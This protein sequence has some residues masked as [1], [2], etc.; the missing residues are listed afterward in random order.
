MARVRLVIDWAPY[1]PGS[2]AELSQKRAVGHLL[3]EAP[4]W[5]EIVVGSMGGTIGG[6]HAWPRD[7]HGEASTKHVPYIRD[8]LDYACFGKGT[9]AS[10]VELAGFLNSDII[11]TPKFFT[12]LKYALDTHAGT[13][14][15]SRTDCSIT[16]FRQFWGHRCIARLHGKRVLARVSTD[17][18][19]MKPVTWRR[20]REVMPDFV[21][22]EPYWDTAYIYWA[23]H[24]G[25]EHYVHM[26][27]DECVHLRHGGNWDFTTD[28]AK[29]ARMLYNSFVPPAERVTK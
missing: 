22:G 4:D 11:V 12:A 27:E 6:S 7:G 19:F 13:V 16:R 24:M 10:D 2:S 5:I 3:R 20:C 18:V 9:G 23:H 14:L 21:I 26:R 28:G 15:C 1:G 8:I 25:K 17:G 29:R